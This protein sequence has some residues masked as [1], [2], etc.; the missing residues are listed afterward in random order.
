MNDMLHFND[1]GPN[2]NVRHI[3]HKGEWWFSIVDTVERLTDSP[4]PRVYWGVLKG[5]LE[6]DEGFIELFTKCKQLK[7]ESTDGKKYKTDCANT[8]TLLRIIQSIPSLKAEPF[9]RW[10]AKVGYERIQETAD[11]ELAHQRARSLYENQGHDPDW[12]AKRLRGMAT[13]DELTDEW[14]ARGIKKPQEFATLTAINSKAALG[15]TPSQHKQ[16]KNLNRENLRDHMTTLE[17]IFSEL[18]EAAAKAITQQKDAQGFSE[19]KETAKIGGQIAG[20]ARH[21]LE[22]KLGRSIVN[23]Q[24]FLP[25]STKKLTKKQT[26]D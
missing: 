25:N 4:N 16:I 24:N 18:G 20:N 14:K 3:L 21:E 19:N 2:F 22:Q 15:V 5:R 26:C 11:P 13:R 17:L 6:K 10:L 8:E 12:I 23:P 9:K 7:L 1:E